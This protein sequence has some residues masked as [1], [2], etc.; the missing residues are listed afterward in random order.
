MGMNEEDLRHYFTMHGENRERRAGRLGRGK[1]GTGKSA[2][3]GIAQSLRIQTVKHHLYNEVLL[4]RADIES[5]DGNDIPLRWE[6]RNQATDQPNGTSVTIGDILLERIDTASIIT[7]IER[8]LGHFRVSNPQVA[9]NKHVCEYHEP[10]VALFRT[11]RPSGIQAQHLN[12]SM[13][14]LQS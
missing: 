1:F 2:A 13:L 11:F 6:I 9:V 10:Q 5:S 3:F 12:T 4:T 14:D 7:Y 8:H